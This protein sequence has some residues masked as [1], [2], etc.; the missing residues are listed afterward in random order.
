MRWQMPLFRTGGIR[1]ALLLVN[2]LQRQQL[3]PTMAS[4]IHFPF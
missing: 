1:K 3:T 4:I 2:G